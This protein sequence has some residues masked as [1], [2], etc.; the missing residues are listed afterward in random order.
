MDWK[1][2]EDEA[3]NEGGPSA[4]RPLLQVSHRLSMKSSQLSEIINFHLLSSSDDDDEDDA[5]CQKRDKKSRCWHRVTNEPLT[6]E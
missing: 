5:I 3:S 6:W 4:K 1:S 2:L